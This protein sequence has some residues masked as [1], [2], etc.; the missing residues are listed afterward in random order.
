[1]KKGIRIYIITLLFVLLGVFS[2]HS[3]AYANI[4]PP[5]IHPPKIKPPSFTPPSPP[6]APSIK[7]PTVNPE[8]TK[9]N[10]NG[11]GGLSDRL[12]G[13]LK[14]LKNRLGELWDGISQVAG[15]IWGKVEEYGT[16]LWESIKEHPILS[17]LIAIGVIAAFMSGVGEVGLAAGG[18]GAGAGELGI[19]GLLGTLFTGDVFT[20]G[21]SGAAS[22]GI[23]RLVAGM[24]ARS[25]FGVWAVDTFGSWFGRAIPNLLSGS[26]SAFTDSALYDWLKNRKIDWGKAGKSAL[27]GFAVLFGVHSTPQLVSAFNKIPLPSPVYQVFADGSLSASPKTIG[28]TSFGQWLQRFASIGEENTGKINATNDVDPNIVGGVKR[29]PVD[30]GQFNIV[31]KHF[32]IPPRTGDNDK[33]TVAVLRMDGREYWSKN[34]KWKQKAPGVEPNFK[35]KEEY[36]KIRKLLGTNSESAGHAEGMAF[37]QALLYRQQKGITGGKAVLYVDK[38]PCG[39]CKRSGIKPLMRAVGLDELDLYYLE[40]GKMHYVRFYRDPNNPK[41]ILNTPYPTENK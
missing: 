15:N 21:I 4:N 24:L 23:F 35:S 7:P 25:R 6:K 19:G 16:K 41:K 40:G 38:V 22:A 10:E 17:I 30:L 28:D 29:P 8:E 14:K 13:G 33:W 2:L 3:V 27:L 18:I 39:F 11:G 36:D 26:V 12:K 1:M 31:R 5:D 34:G 20:G 37:Y 32:N 9:V